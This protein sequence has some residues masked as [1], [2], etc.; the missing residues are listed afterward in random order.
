MCVGVCVEVHTHD[1]GLRLLVLEADSVG[2]DFRFLGLGFGDNGF[3]CG[4]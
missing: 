1:M 3:G 2:P 4:V